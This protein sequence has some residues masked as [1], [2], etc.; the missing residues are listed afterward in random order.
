LTRA[1]GACRAS[2][3]SNEFQPWL[4]G[5]ARGPAKG[6]EFGLRLSSETKR[7]LIAFLKTL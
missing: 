3:D 2:L 4:A 7:A 1:G 6:H 5:P